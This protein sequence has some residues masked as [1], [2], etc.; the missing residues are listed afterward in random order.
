MR[1][2]AL[3]A[4]LAWRYL[5]AP[6]SHS[7]VSAIS[8]ISVVGVAV[9]TA[10]IVCVLSVFNGFKGMIGHNLNKLSPDVQVAPVMGKT[11]A[12]ADSVER[13]ISAIDG[14][15]VV[16]PSVTDNALAL[17]GSR[18]MPVTLMGVVPEKYPLVTAVDS[19][20]VDGGRIASLSD[21]G[22]A[23]A[24]GVSQQLGVAAQG[25]E[26]LL[27]APRRE[28][29]VNLSNPMASFLTDSVSVGGIFQTLQADYDLNG[30]ICDISTARE[31][32]QYGDEVTSFEIK[33]RAGA[34][35][36]A[37]AEEI[38]SALGP[39]VVVK[40]R[41]RLQ[42]T[43]FRMVAIEKWVTFLFLIFILVI[44]S[45]NIMSTMC[46]LI[47]EKERSISVFSALGMSRRRVGATFW[48]ESVYVCLAGGVAGVALGVLLCVLQEQ[49]GLLR[50]SGD[51]EL[52]VVNAYPVKVEWSDLPI[53]LAPV[54]AIGFVT[55]WISS[56]FAR[57][58][59]GK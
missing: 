53:A 18:E 45:F 44:A 14:V 34:D 7:A 50:F 47:L 2:G 43:H 17:Y 8:I 35:A 16:M 29:K 12:G 51:P 41:F 3:S 20:F 56:A 27:F 24:V 6:K 9:A 28:G 21:G 40:D 58:R 59:A 19:L 5:R 10:A 11:I 55:A 23:I 37:V 38:A 42:E 22:V 25:E 57:S 1:P 48:W 31:L 4:L 30:V 32:F 46:M 54:V 49:F 13:I 33:T 39:G 26:L 52:L 15:E 36:G